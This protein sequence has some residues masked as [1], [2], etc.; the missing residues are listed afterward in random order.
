MMNL[1]V[2]KHLVCE[3]DLVPLA[4]PDWGRKLIDNPD[5]TFNINYTITIT[6]IFIIINIIII[7]NILSLFLMNTIYLHYN[8]HLKQ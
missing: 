6:I 5:V 4:I 1:Q 8:S 7:T 2:K 3:H